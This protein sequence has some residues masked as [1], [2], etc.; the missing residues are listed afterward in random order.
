MTI[1]HFTYYGIERLWRG[2]DERTIYF[3][4]CYIFTH[5]K[6]QRTNEPVPLEPN[7]HP[8]EIDFDGVFQSAAECGSCCV[9]AGGCPRTNDVG[10][11]PR[12]RG[13]RTH[14]QLDLA[15]WQQSNQPKSH[16]RNSGNRG[17]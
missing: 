2:V 11:F 3:Y 17:A 4:E 1:D 5:Y 15:K 7:N 8:N 10:G 6:A 9:V 12:D 13:G 16:V 14:G